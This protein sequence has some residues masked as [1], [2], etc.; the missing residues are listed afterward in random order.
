[1]RERHS[2]LIAEALRVGVWSAQLFIRPTMRDVSSTGRQFLRQPSANNRVVSIEKES[3]PHARQL[4]L[5]TATNP[6]SSRLL[7]DALIGKRFFNQ[8][9]S[10]S[11]I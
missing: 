11:P 3:P 2:C 8:R 7:A 1:M 6:R 10:P 5:E 9:T 4:L